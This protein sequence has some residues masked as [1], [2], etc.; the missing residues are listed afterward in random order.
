MSGMTNEQYNS[1]LELLAKLIEATAK[2][3]TEAAAI[4][5]DAKVKTKTPAHPKAPLLT[6]ESENLAVPEVH[7]KEPENDK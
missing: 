2:T 3:P 4:V 7:V 5:R 1:H 6:F